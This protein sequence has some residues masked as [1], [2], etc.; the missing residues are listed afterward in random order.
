[1]V[2]RLPG[3]GFLIAGGA[4]TEGWVKTA[5]AELYDPTTDAWS[6]PPPMPEIGAN[7]RTLWA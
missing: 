3:G 4:G 5:A 6:E 2:A 1:M 7:G